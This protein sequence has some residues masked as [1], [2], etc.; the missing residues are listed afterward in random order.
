[1]RKSKIEGESFNI[2]TVIIANF[3]DIAPCSSYVNWRF[4]GKYHLHLQGRQ[5]AEKETS[6]QQVARQPL[7]WAQ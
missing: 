4:R 1:M 7:I 5:S 2:F 3:W 6:V